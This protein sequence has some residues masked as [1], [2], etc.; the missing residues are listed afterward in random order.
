MKMYG[1]VAFIAFLLISMV[2]FSMSVFNNLGGD[3]SAQLNDDYSLSENFD[4]SRS[5]FVNPNQRDMDEAQRRAFNWRIIRDYFFVK[6]QREPVQ[7]LPR[8]EPD[9]E[10]LLQSD[11]QLKVI[12]FG[13]SSF[14]LNME[15]TIILVDPVFGNASPFSFFGRRY[16]D[17]VSTVEDLPDIDVVLISHDHYDHLEADTIRFFAGT[18]TQFI[19]PLG[20]GTH[21]MAWGIEKG[22]IIERDWW[23]S[24]EWGS[25]SFTATPAQ[26]FSGRKGFGGNQCLWA[27]WVLQSDQH[28][29]YF[30]GDGGYGSHFSEIGSRYGP[31]DVAFM[32]T[33]QYNEAWRMIHMLPEEGVKAFRDLRAERYFPVHW[34]M[35]T[36]ALH[37]WYE[38]IETITQLA[39]KNDFPLITPVIGQLVDVS[40]DTN[41]PSWWR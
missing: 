31:F 29:V 7:A 20:V 32:E 9:Y 11:S 22:R 24:A 38:P 37:R 35:F 5:R 33:G 15:G 36:L 27:S 25:V 18:E 1:C 8:Q 3:F 2:Y 13:H 28:S 14:L 19:V 4:V 34:G 39:E 16:M 12:W 40:S 21:L 30:S 41:F 23:Q 26:H 10:G 6:N 17:P